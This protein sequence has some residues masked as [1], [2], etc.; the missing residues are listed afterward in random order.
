VAALGGRHAAAAAAAFL[1][2]GGSWPDVR[3]PIRCEP[4]L[5]WI[6]PN[7]VVAGAGAPPR[8]RFALR[9]AS[10]AQ[11]PCV[12]IEQAGRTLWSGR[13]RR[14]VPGRSAALPH[15]W[16]ASVDPAGGPVSVRMTAGG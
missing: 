7:V 10:F 11:R 8:G 4:P 5:G 3:V 2:N 15:A 9:S 13:L 12:E 1:A 6:A 14:L 16:T